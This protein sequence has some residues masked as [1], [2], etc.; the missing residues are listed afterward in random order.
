M[1]PPKINIEKMQKKGIAECIKGQLDSSKYMCAK[2]GADVLE[3][4]KTCNN[5]D[6]EY[7]ILKPKYECANCGKPVVENWATCRNCGGTDMVLV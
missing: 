5:C 6:S 3:D 1:K 2:C 4:W 7:M